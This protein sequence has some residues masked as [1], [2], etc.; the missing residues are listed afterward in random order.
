MRLTGDSPPT[1]QELNEIF[2][3]FD[4]KPDRSFGEKVGGAFDAAATMATGALA[5]PVAGLAGLARTAISGPEAGARR[6]EDLQSMLTYKPG[7]VGQEYLQNI[8][9]APVIKQIG[10]VATK[11]ADYAGR[12]TYDITGSPLAASVAQGIPEAAG[13]ALGA[14]APG[15]IAARQAGKA[16]EVTQ[17]GASAAVRGANLTE[18]IA[19]SGTAK[20]LK[21]LKKSRIREIVDADPSFYR[22]LDELGITA[23]PLPSYASRNPQFIGI[24]QSFAALPNSPQNAQSLVFARDV[25]NV[26]HALLETAEGAGNSVGTSLTWRDASMKTIK[27]LG[28]AADEA[29]DSLNQVLDRRAPAEPVNTMQFLDDFAKDLALGIDDPDVPAVIK[30]AYASLQ[31]RRVETDTGTQMVPAT[32][33]NMDRLRKNI[34]AA[35]FKNQGDFKDADSALLTRLYSSLTDD[36]HEMA[37]K[38]GLSTEAAA[39]K[40]LVAQRK[41]LEERMQIL[42]GEDLQGDIVPVVQKGI[43]GLRG[44]G[45]QRY[46]EIMDNIPEPEVRQELIMT[47]LDDMF[48]KT[49]RG[50]K[51]FGTLDYLKW[52]NDTIKNKSVRQFIEADLPADTMKAL[53]NLAVISEGV[54]RAT[55]QRI[56]TGVVNSVLNDDTGFVS[57]MMGITAKGAGRTLQATPMMQE[58]G[59]ALINMIAG[60]SKRADSVRDLLAEPEFANMIRRGVAQGVVDGRRASESVRLAE[61]RL[62]RTASYK[63]WQQT[64]TEGE[65]AKLAGAGLAAFLLSQ[66]ED[67]ND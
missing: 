52:Y 47:A 17:E 4:V 11:G 67:E 57:R 21:S 65:R 10:E 29:Y 49:V 61:S 1:E 58:T 34:G 28:R 27:E 62:K 19:G 9:E 32:L 12:K 63:A 42:L 6:V 56:S 48:S 2:S 46:R 41:Q 13:V 25:S 18:N 5:Q 45:A 35:A 39:A 38:Q 33:E 26:A 54:A 8:A 15:G 53:D 24:E 22:A 50:E 66:E 3:Q 36:I 23:E 64:L 7:K 59:T 43:K 51:Q 55:A 40:S 14:Y 30:R 16:A 37:L 44:G 60:R 31:P 20:A